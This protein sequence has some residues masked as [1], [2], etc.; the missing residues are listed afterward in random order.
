MSFHKE[1]QSSSAGE[2][3]AT[4][5]AELGYDS[6]EARDL[7]EQGIVKA[8]DGARNRAARQERL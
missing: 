6:D 4:I 8:A 5:L 1:F 2:Q 7:E 3:T